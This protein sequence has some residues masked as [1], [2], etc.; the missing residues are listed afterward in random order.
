MGFELSEADSDESDGLTDFGHRVV[1]EMHKLGMVADLSHVSPQTFDDVLAMD[2][3]APFASHVAS[4]SRH[5][6]CRNLWDAQ[7][8]A[9]AERGGVLG[10]TLVPGFLGPAANLETAIAHARHIIDVGGAEVLGIGT[11]FDGIDVGP[12]DLKDCTGLPSLVDGVTDTCGLDAEQKRGI[13][14][15]NVLRV[16]EAWE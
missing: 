3:P 12:I 16:F 10:L 11:D 13:A 1:E 15:A 14:H 8:Q 2:L 7:I 4:R 5:D 9:L 6:H